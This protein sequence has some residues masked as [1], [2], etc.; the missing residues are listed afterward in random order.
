MKICILGGGNIGTLL[1]GDIG[2]KSDIS[3]RLLTSKPD[4]WE[5]TIEVYREDGVSTHTGKIDV[6]SNN[7]EEVVV[8]ADIILST[9]PSHVFPETM[10]K[11]SPFIKSGTWIGVMPGSGGTEFY[12]KKLIERGCILFGFQRVH[13][14]ARIKEYGKSV[15]D[16]G[17]KKE[18][19]IATIPVEKGEEVCRVM[20]DLFNIKCIALPN[21]LN[22]TLTPSNQI[23][24]TTRLC[25]MFYHY[26]EGVYWDDIMYFYSDWTDQASRLLIMCDGELQS[27]C[28]VLSPLDL[29]G[30]RP[31]IEY[32]ESDTPE[33]MTEKIRSI[34]AF[35]NI[36]APM[37][38]TDKGY[39]PDLRSR[40]FIEDFPYGLCI[41]KDFCKIVG[42]DTPAIDKVLYWFQ[43]I[44]GYEYFV[45]GKFEGKDLKNLPLPENYGLK[46]KEKIIAYYNV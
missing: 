6:I 11:I 36:K 9:V 14:I 27:L 26:E 34:T 41:I 15:Y 18:L 31:L 4:E 40:Y 24:H 21:Y 13:G 7:P 25:S 16:L 29:S 22:V 23:L 45:R 39:I 28:R 30:V 37:I 8:G 5:K 10:R 3:I 35:K 43:R 2:Q 17:K 19:Y 12:C 1:V 33:K 38:A 20:E 32:Y 46:S 42:L 44:A